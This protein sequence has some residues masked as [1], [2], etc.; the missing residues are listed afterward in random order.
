LA[1]LLT[2][3]SV[4][5]PPEDTDEGTDEDVEEGDGDTFDGN[6][7]QPLNEIESG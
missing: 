6:E 4:T 2:E 1:L 5:P 3:S 7:G